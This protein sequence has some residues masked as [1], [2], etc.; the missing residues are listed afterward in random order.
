[1]TTRHRNDFAQTTNTKPRGMM[2]EGMLLFHK[3]SSI[4]HY[5]KELIEMTM[6]L[7]VYFLYADA[8]LIREP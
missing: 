1:M 4:S 2:S 7:L 8:S 6:G 3:G 5:S